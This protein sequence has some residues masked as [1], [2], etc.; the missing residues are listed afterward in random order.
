MVPQC[1]FITCRT[2]F[3][4]FFRFQELDFEVSVCE[5]YKQVEILDKISEGKHMQ[6]DDNHSKD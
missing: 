6:N 1:C 4:L 2:Y 3:D 5:N